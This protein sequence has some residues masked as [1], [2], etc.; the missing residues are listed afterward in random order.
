MPNKTDSGRKRGR[1]RSGNRAYCIRMS[2]ET[3]GLLL[4]MARCECAFWDHHLTNLVE[5]IAA[6]WAKKKEYLASKKAAADG[7][8]ASILLHVFE[9]NEALSELVLKL[10]IDPGLA[11]GPDYEL[12]LLKVRELCQ[13]LIELMN[14][15]GHP[16]NPGD[17]PPA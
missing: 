5:T 3:H 13:R 2:P 16:K 15:D 4:E 10:E 17:P 8:V 9:A 14:K 12:A 6:T 11:A 7:P 1:P